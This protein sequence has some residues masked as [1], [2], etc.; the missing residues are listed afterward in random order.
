MQYDGLGAGLAGGEGGEDG[1]PRKAYGEMKI[2]V[3][4][5]NMGAA[6]PFAELDFDNAAHAAEVCAV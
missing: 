3:G 4:S 5:W 6:D 1:A 2:W